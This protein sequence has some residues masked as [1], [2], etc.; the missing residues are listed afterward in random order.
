MNEPGGINKRT[1]GINF[2]GANAF[3]LVWSPKA[4]EVILH[5]ESRN[6]DLKLLASDLGYWHLQTNEIKPGDLY[7]FSIDGGHKLPDP[8]SLSQPLGVDKASQA[9]DLN[10]YAWSDE[11]WQNPPIG[12][13]IIYELHVGTFSEESSFLGVIKHLDDLKDLG[14]TG[15][16]IMPVA[17][18]SGVRNWGYDGV[19]PFAVQNTYGGAVAFQQLVDACHQKGIAVIL[20]VVYNH[21][22]P[23]GNIFEEY[24]PYF[25]DKYKT[26]WGKAINFDDAYCDPVR[27]FYLENALTWLRDFHVDALRLDAVHAIKDYG[28]IHIIE[29]LSDLV[30]EYNKNSGTKKYLI[31]ETDLNDIRFVRDKEKCGFGVD[32]QW[33]DEFHH[34][35]RVSAGQERQGYYAD[36]N[37][38]ADLAKSYKDAYVF[39]GQYSHHRHRKFGTSTTGISGDRFIVFAQNHDQVGNRMMGER[40]SQLVSFEMQKLI[41]AVI[42]T[43]PF[44]PLLFMGE[45]WGTGTPFPYFVDFS[46]EELRA[47]IVKGRKEEF[48]QFQTQGRPPIPH[49]PETFL[50]A[51]LKWK[52]RRE[53]QHGILFRF[54]KK[55]IG[56]RKT[57]PPL[58]NYERSAVEVFCE[59]EKGILILDRS[60]KEQHVYCLFN[61]SKEKRTLRLKEETVSKRLLLASSDLNWKGKYDMPTV[62]YTSQINIEPESVIL[63][64]NYNVPA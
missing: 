34:A 7:C 14:I 39:T 45:E 25:T 31:A 35:L 18:F 37:G 21:L 2:I 6:L 9:I 53:G 40:L 28:A 42:L 29:E 26:P 16:E 17:Q 63:L 23:E 43:S 5:N 60:F 4:K 32:A 64:A 12:N 33:C 13:Y 19:F 51:Q 46:N 57:E 59:E 11:S 44:V 36:F 30:E 50:S 8:A 47:A 54:Y 41:A 48:A 27:R 10:A 1:L 61:F 3:V 20:D 38:L 22:G 15:I 55:L 49:K 24:G 52:E 62:D 58:M 56:L